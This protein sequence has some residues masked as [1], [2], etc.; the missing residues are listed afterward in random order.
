MME[1][2]ERFTDAELVSVIEQALIYMCACPAQVAQASRIEL[3]NQ[4]RNRRLGQS[5]PLCAFVVVRWR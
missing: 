1:Y 4:Q 2:E 5:F 3:K